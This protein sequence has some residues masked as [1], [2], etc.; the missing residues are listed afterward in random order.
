M[1]RVDQ[2]AIFKAETEN[3]RRLD[4]ARRQIRRTIQNAL[5]RGDTP[6]ED[7]HSVVLALLYCAWL[8]ALFVKI[9]HT[10]YGLGVAELVRIR[11]EQN[12]SGIHQAWVRCVDVGLGR[13]AKGPR[14]NEI[15]NM[16]LRL[17]RLIDEFVQEPSVLRNKI[18]HGQWAVAL[19]RE[20]TAANPDVSARLQALDIVTLDR[21][22]EVAKHLAEIIEALIESPE[23]HFRGAYWSLV[24]QLEERVAE[25]SSWTRASRIAQLRRKPIPHPA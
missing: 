21:W 25:M 18:A 17:N 10:P 12:A 23:R 9:T 4:G 5:R 6:A 24:T 11:E 8:E 16:R 1:D 7:A 20:R 19:N 13:V 15:P 2:L 3:V 14:P 22:F